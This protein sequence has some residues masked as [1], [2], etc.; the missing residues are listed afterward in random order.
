M[1][2]EHNETRQ[3][4]RE[5]V[6]G[7]TDR[8]DRREFV[9][10]ARDGEGVD[11]VWETL[12]ELGLLGMGV[13][14][15]Y[16]G[17]GGG[18]T[19]PVAVIEA[20]SQ[21]GTP[22]VL[23]LLTAFARMA[24]L[25]HGTEEQIQQ[26]VAPTCTGEVKLCFAITEADA[27]TNSFRMETFAEQDGDVYRINGQKIFIS[28]A[29]QA[30]HMMVVARTT[31]LRDTDDKRVGLSLFVLPMDSPG[32]E[33]QQMDI[34]LHSPE[35]QFF[36]FLN[37]VEVPAANLVGTRDEG[38]R[39]L[40]DAL[41]P[42]RLLVSAWALGLGD[43]VLAKGVEYASTRAP[44][45]TPIG[46]YQAVQHPLARAKAHLEAARLMLYSACDTYDAGGDAGWA[47]NMAKL[48]ASEAANEAVDAVMQAHGGSAFDRDTD[49]I[50]LWPM[51]RLLRI[52]PVNN[53]MV[54][55]YLAERVLGLPKSY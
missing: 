44:F 52:A 55:N 45:G 13:P 21:A 5:V 39:A 29:D 1:S 22:P 27:G 50:T 19:G 54:L 2:I 43:H 25:R 33:L 14:E 38:L 47:A 10:R 36:V 15:E 9:R 11:D 23:V 26:F 6:K 49:V 40:F 20:L 31:R 4:V 12:G 3:A 46:S 18:M 7:V 30:T 17:N 48:L 53:E 8:F 32:L 37:D 24:I 35:H 51:I 42:E 16:G 34:D 28:G 41:N